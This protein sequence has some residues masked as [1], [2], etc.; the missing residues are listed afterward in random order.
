[1]DEFHDSYVPLYEKGA[2]PKPL[3]LLFEDKK[4]VTFSD[5]LKRCKQVYQDTTV[6]AAQVKMVEEKTR[7]QS[8]SKLWFQQRAGRVTTSKLRSVLHTKVTNPSKS[9]LASICYPESARF[10]SEACMYG[11]W[12][13]EDGRKAYIDLMSNQHESFSVSKSGLVLDESNPFIGASPDGLVNS[14]CCGNGTLEI[15]SPF[16]CR[17]KDFQEASKEKSIL[18]RV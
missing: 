10:S 5:L 17:D 8:R 7:S 12:H 2:L 16:S 4:F 13:E 11:C 1:M 15:K 14:L 6:T 3:S 18:F 9:L